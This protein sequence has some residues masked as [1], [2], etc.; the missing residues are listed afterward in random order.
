MADVFASIAKIVQ[1]I[2]AL[3]RLADKDY[4]VRSVQEGIKK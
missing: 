1:L 3:R 4:F 2:L